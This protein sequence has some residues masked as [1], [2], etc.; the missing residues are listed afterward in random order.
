[1]SMIASSTT[2]PTATA[3]PAR[4][5]VLMVAPVMSSTIAA[6][7]RD[8]GIASRLTSAARHW[9]RNVIS[10][11]TT[12]MQPRITERL[13]LWMAVSMKLAWRKMCESMRTPRRPGASRASARSTPLVTCRVLAPGN[14]STT[15]IRPGPPLI[16]ASPVSGGVPQRTRATW[17]IRRIWLPR[18]VSGTWA[19]CCGVLIGWMFLTSRRWSGVCTKPSEPT[20]PP[21]VNL[22]SRVSTASAAAVIS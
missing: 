2:T 18:L 10:T 13:R 7:A 12:R 9:N 5:I 22:I 20:A 6:V 11:N 19:I 14:F 3:N 17:P 16:T 21:V 1:M 8:S 15:I 4:I